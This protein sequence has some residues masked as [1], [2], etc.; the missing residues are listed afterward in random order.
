MEALGDLFPAAWRQWEAF[1][2]K[3]PELRMKCCKRTRASMVSNFAVEEAR[4][5]FADMSP[6]AILHEARRFLLVEFDSQL[7]LRLKKFQEGT[8]RTSG[9]NTRQRKAFAAQE[10]LTGMPEATNLVLGYEV[11][12]D[13]TEIISTAITCKTLGK[14]HWEIPIALPG[15][16]VPLEPRDRQTEIME[17]EITSTRLDREEAQG[18]RDR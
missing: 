15:Q 18:G 5:V 17:P 3:M 6:T 11:D 13:G 14:L 10:P 9:I 4:I 7:C 16:A 8:R 2:E 12:Q 1:G